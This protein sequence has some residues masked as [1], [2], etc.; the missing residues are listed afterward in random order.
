[1]YHQLKRHDDWTDGTMM[2]DTDGGNEDKVCV[3][4]YTDD[5]SL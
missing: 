3:S 2:E 1:M 4:I 5:I